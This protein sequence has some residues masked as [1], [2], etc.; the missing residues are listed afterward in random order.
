MQTAF[1][2]WKFDHVIPVNASADSDSDNDGIQLLLEYALNLDPTN[3][4]VTGLPSGAISN[5]FLTLTYTKVKTATDI[6]YAAEVSGALS[7]MWS[8]SFDDVEQAWL[9]TDHGE[10][11]AVT[12]R[13][14]I[15][16]T[17][18]PS[19]FMRLKVTQP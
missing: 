10:T 5:N 12:A 14:K 7:G 17:S 19:R 6:S 4:S 11:E 13:D 3:S 1:N 15:S 2:Q 9:V 18:A 8:S 16:V